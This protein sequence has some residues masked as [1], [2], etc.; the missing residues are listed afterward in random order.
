VQ[1]ATL[2]ISDKIVEARSLRLISASGFGSAI[3]VAR[4]V[5]TRAEIIEIITLIF[6]LHW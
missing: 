1:E 6:A 4:V 5:A 3:G 2:S